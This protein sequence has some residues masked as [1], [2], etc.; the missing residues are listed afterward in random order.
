MTHPPISR[1]GP[2]GTGNDLLLAAAIL[3]IAFNLRPAIAAVGPLG[4]IT[5]EDKK[6]HW[7]GNCTHCMACI[8]GCPS[9]AIEY[10]RKS[11]GKPRY[12]IRED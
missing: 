11:K 12:Y 2:H 7:N 1:N 10:K 8:G 5:M 9:E 3:L 6:P 4:N